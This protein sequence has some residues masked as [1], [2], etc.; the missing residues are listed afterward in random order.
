ML[1][2]ELFLPH[3]YTPWH[4]IQNARYNSEEQYHSMTIRFQA[5]LTLVQE[6][7][8]TF[9]HGTIRYRFL[10]VFKVGSW[11]LPN[12]RQVS[13]WR[14]SGYCYTIQNSLTGLSPYIVLHSRRLRV[15]Q[16]RLK[17][18]PITPHLPYISTKDSVCLNP[19]SVALTNGISLISFPAGTKMFQFPAFPCLSAL[20]RSR[21]RRSWVQCI[22]AARPSI[23]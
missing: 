6:F 13:S 17:N 16:R 1:L 23:S 3:T 14:Y 11:C 19:R 7:F 4:V 18:S 22:H 5:L 21:I 8:S 15:L 9:P 2:L 20:L 10:D 12:S